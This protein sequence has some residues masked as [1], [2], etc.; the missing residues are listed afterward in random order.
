MTE[1]WKIQEIQEEICTRVRDNNPGIVA[2]GV[3]L[4]VWKALEIPKDIRHTHGLQW[5]LFTEIGDL[6]DVT[7]APKGSY[8]MTA[9]YPMGDNVESNEGWSYGSMCK[10]SF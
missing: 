8:D 1:S 10:Y 4:E 3:L 2:R 6:M 5:N 7:V 9:S